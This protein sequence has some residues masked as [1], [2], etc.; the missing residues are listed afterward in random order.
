MWIMLV[1][2][3]ADVNYACP[4]TPLVVA[5]TEGLTDCMKYLLQVHADPNI[6]DKQVCAFYSLLFSLK[7]LSSQC[8]I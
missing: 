1:Q 3:G 5:T 7:L 6:P 4:N 8:M 2:A